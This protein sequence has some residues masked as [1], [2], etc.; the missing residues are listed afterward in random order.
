MQKY[1]SGPYLSL[2]AEAT[3]KDGDSV[4]M[5][6]SESATIYISYA[7]SGITPSTKLTVEVSPDGTNFYS[8]DEQTKTATGSH[9]VNFNNVNATHVRASQ[10]G[11]AGTVETT[12]VVMLGSNR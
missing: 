11:V 1:L 2:D 5:A 4:A 7:L 12:A 9:A 8:I 6:N 10:S 3:N